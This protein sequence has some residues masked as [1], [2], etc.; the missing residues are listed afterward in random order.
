MI[1]APGIWA[2]VNDSFLIDRQREQEQMRLAGERQRQER[3]AWDFQTAQEDRQRQ[4]RARAGA[5]QSVYGMVPP[6]VQPQAPQPP[7][8]GQSSGPM[9]P[10]GMGA[11]QP[12][13]MFSQ[14]PAQPQ[15]AQRG[16]P[17]PLPP[18]PY[19]ALPT[20]APQQPAQ[21]QQSAGP[22][23]PPP[24]VSAP[25]PGGG[26][27]L[28]QMATRAK[29]A[30]VPPADFMDQIEA[31]S[32]VLK[33]QMSEEMLALRGT[34]A[35]QNAYFKGA[36]LAL[37][38]R[39]EDRQQEQGDRR[40]DQNAQRISLAK[41][42]AQSGATPTASELQDPET[43]RI[44]YDIYKVSGKT[45]PFAWGKAGEADRTAWMQAV[46]RFS[47]DDGQSGGE[48]AGGQADAKAGAA[49]LTQNTKDLAAIRPYK[50]MLDKNAAVAI[51]LARKVELTDS[52][53][54]NRPIQWL[55]A[56]GGSDPNLREYLAQIQIVQTEAARVLNNP[57]LVGQLT[58][59]ARHEMQDILKG[60]M[61]LKDTERVLQRMMKDGENRVKALEDEN[62]SLKRSA[63]GKPG[64]APASD[65]QDAQAIAWAKA[66]P[67]DPRAKKIL[68]LHGM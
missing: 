27:L 34:I 54:A 25:Q 20:G 39:R 10:P 62:A 53:L 55:R 35:E 7:A 33:N 67:N 59:S 23:S 57:R 6:P 17:T 29:A 31:L 50:V 28:M 5:G 3:A 15:P 37:Q 41:Q 48:V 16:A 36:M 65:D 43:A 21:P 40:L 64:A 60:T 2:G 46:K 13:Q 52:T 9:M 45:P 18:P 1:G 19:R 56:N 47:K 8:P 42:R 4:M 38:G 61:P 44:F 51:D 26:G 68:S 66:N 30:G 63:S 24:V 14:P 12:P 11:G 58:D 32:P 49:A 22:G